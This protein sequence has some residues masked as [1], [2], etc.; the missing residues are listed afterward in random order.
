MTIR[1]LIGVLVG[2]VTET[3][4]ELAAFTDA[5]VLLNKRQY[6]YNRYA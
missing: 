5:N 2:D 4:A 3:A 1:F 6:H